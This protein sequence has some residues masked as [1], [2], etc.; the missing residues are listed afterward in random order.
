MWFFTGTTEKKKSNYSRDR[1]T[2]I[3][4]K[5]IQGRNIKNIIIV[6]FSSMWSPLINTFHTFLFWGIYSSSLWLFQYLYFR[7]PWLFISDSSMVSLPWSSKDTANIL[8][9]REKFRCELYIFFPQQLS[10]NISNM[11]VTTLIILY[12]E[13]F[14]RLLSVFVPSFYCTSELTWY[15]N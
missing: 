14:M 15:W 10:T 1:T 3:D 11:C 9:L 12:T 4:G 2:D 7:F 6:S 8:L 13:I 5:C